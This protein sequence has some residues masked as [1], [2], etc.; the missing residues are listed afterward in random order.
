[1]KKFFGKYYKEV[2]GFVGKRIDDAGAAEEITSDILLSAFNG[3]TRFEGRSS[4]RSWVYAIARHKIIDYYRKKKLKTILFSVSPV[5]EEIADRA[6]TP[7]RDCLKNELK[8][9]IKKTFKKI[10]EG[11][12]KV[13][14]LKY[15]EGWSVAKIAKGLAVS[16]K[17]IESR[18]SRARGKFRQTWSYEKTD[19]KNSVVDGIDSG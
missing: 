4:E 10:N 6:L 16:I 9:E 17:A 1:V 14:R 11:Y 13:L 5:F 2:L 19:K 8:G 15:I 12:S 18:L 3:L 7:E